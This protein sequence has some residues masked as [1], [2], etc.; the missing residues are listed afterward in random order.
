MNTPIIHNIF[1]MNLGTECETNNLKN[2]QFSSKFL[3]DPIYNKLLFRTVP[4]INLL[5]L[6]S[7]YFL[8]TKKYFL[9]K[10]KNS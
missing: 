6:L 1:G 3:V 2:K 10:F 8:F 5:T 4:F 7:I 9:N